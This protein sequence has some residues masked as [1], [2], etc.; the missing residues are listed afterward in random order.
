MRGIGLDR[1][2]VARYVAGR[3]VPG[4]GYCFYRT[5][6]WGVEEPNAPDTFAALRSLGLLDEPVPEPAQTAGWLRSLQGGDGSYP[7][8]TIAWAALRGLDE[9]AAVPERSSAAWLCSWRDRLLVPARPG[10]GRWPGA[11]VTALRLVE[12]LQRDGLAVPVDAVGSLLRASCDPAGGWAAPGA[13]L[14]TSATALLLAERVGAVALE[15]R[16]L[17]GLV[18]ACEDPVLGFQLAPGSRSVTTGALWGGLVLV[19]R[20]GL[21]L[22]HAA[23]IASGLRGAQRL[24]GGVGR[25]PGAIS[26]LWDTLLALEADLQL[27]QLL[28]R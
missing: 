28:G 1:P 10:N 15:P 27:E 26:T 25:R 20:L 3:R 13:D 12:L 7:T 19:D 16:R 6:A 21:E 22:H 24:D 23:A 17:G 14:E 2:A 9:L 4:A 5:P 8:L 18:H 11:L